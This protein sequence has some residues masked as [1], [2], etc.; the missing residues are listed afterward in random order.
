MKAEKQMSSRVWRMGSYGECQVHPNAQLAILL[1]SSN[2][3]TAV[4]HCSWLRGSGKEM[5]VPHSH[6]D[7]IR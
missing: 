6:T 7:M 2:W 5:V 4:E 1:E 3:D